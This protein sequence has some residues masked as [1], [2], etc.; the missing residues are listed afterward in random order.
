[1]KAALRTAAL[2]FVALVEL[3]DTRTFPPLVEYAGK[4]YALS[5]GPEGGSYHEVAR[6]VVPANVGG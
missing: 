1:M 2:E 5:P 4:L 3:P 6:V